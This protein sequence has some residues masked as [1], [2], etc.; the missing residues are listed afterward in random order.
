M[1]QQVVAVVYGCRV[2][3]GLALYDDESDEGG[4][5]EQFMAAEYERTGEDV[6]EN[7]PNYIRQDD[8]YRVMGA[9]L[10]PILFGE[11]E[12]EPLDLQDNPAG[13]FASTDEGKFAMAA[14]TRFAEW[15]KERGHDFGEPRF[16]IAVREVA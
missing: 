8:A 14:W 9:W 4:V 3:D 12:F 10:E 7:D 1:G 6:G 15:A 2:P 11:D 16:W 13:R 5:I